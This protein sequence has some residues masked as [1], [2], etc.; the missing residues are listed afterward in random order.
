MILQALY[1]YYQ[2]KAADPDSMIAPYGLEWKEIPYLIVIDEEGNF[3]FIEDTQ[4]GEGKQRRGKKFLV[5][6]AKGRSGSASWQTAQVFWDH[7]GYVAAQTKSGKENDAK[8]RAMVVNQNSSFVKLVNAI[9][10]QFPDNREFRAVALFYANPDNLAALKADALWQD[11]IAK[12]GRN[13]SFRVGMSP[14]IVASH[15]NLQA[16]ARRSAEEG[17][18]KIGICLITGERGPLVTLTT[19]TPIIGGKSNGKIVAFQKNQGYD[20]YGKEQ[21]DNAPISLEAEDAFSSALKTMLSPDS[22]NNFR[23]SDTTV[24]FWSQK[25]TRFEEFFPCSFC[26]AP[27]DNPD[28][29]VEQI[30]SLMKGIRSGVLNDEG[31]TPFYILGL[32]PNAARIAIRFWKRGTVREFADNLRRHFSDLEIVR[33]KHEEREYFSLFNLLDNV[34]FQYKMDNLP[35]NLAADMTRSI[36]DNRPYPTTLMTHC[37]N[38]IRADRNI[39]AVRAA[40]IKAYLCRKYR[41]TSFHNHKPITMALDLQN[42]NQAY[43]CGRLFAVLEKIQEDAQPGI[44]A[45]IK[46]RF[47]GAASTAPVTVFPRL[48]ALSNN[49]LSKIGGGKV[50][51]YGKLLQ[52]I[53][54]NI[55]SLGFPSHL[56]L[57]DQGRFAIGYYHQRQDLF[58]SKTERDS[59]NE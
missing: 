3:C 28:K 13:L 10:G 31:D 49:H 40:V 56:M 12:D 53:F 32:A 50:V 5:T 59:E 14:D 11:V 36:L 20:S 30:R 29:N 22:G 43:L 25:P 16:L 23:L 27:K 58:R 1:E 7:F 19:A 38:R 44:N 4:E 41:Q 8:A 24:I 46:D 54:D 17:E 6:K 51:Y 48:I 2:R 47:Y 34:A 52:S 33:S 18:G 9:A 15:A 55:S 37:I 21:C 42:T 45:T 39:N 35:P 57:D 26:A